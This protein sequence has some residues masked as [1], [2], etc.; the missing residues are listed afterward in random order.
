LDVATVR[1]IEDLVRIIPV[2]IGDAEIPASL[3][4]LVWV[5]LR[6]DFDDGV[7]RIANVIQGISSKPSRPP[8]QPIVEVEPI[9]GLSRAATAIGNLLLNCEESRSDKKSAY[10]GSELQERLQIAPEAINDAVEE[11]FEAGLV[12]VMRAL[13]TAPYRFVQIEPTYVLF[14]EFRS[15]LNY[16]PDE[17]VRVVA[18]AIAARKHVRGREL[19]ELTGLTPDRL[20]RAVEY[21]DDFKIANVSRAFGTAPFN[22]S[23][24]YPT[25]RT[26]R[27]VE[28]AS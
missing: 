11:L 16:D 5:D 12:Q 24:I 7:E 1:R 23:G 2:V 27:F 15:R 3:R 13:G 4:A 9:G 19:E 18:A 28:E 20:N 8:S 6:V 17:D 21:L 26:R 25:H 14:R 22:F 10:L